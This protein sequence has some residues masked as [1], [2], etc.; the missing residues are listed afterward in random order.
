MGIKVSD[1]FAISRVIKV[2]G[3]SIEIHPLSLE[4]IIKLLTIY[5]E[6]IIMMFSDSVNGELNMV[7]MVV[8]APRLV[9]DIISYGINAEDQV[10]DIMKLPGF[11]QVEILAEVW[12]ISIPEPKKLLNLLS[13]AMAGMQGIGVNPSL[14]SEEITPQNS[15]SQIQKE[16]EQQSTTLLPTSENQ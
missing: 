9:A 10:D 5:R 4:Q 3:K 7:T 15:V 6:D 14:P 8:T 16:P 12:K 13:E 11:T 1:L 2:S